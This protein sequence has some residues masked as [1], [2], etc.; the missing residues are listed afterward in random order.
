[1]QTEISQ[2]RATLFLAKNQ[3]LCPHDSMPSNEIV[4]D[5]ILTAIAS[6]KKLERDYNLA[7]FV[8][9]KEEVQNAD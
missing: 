2:I 4:C 5:E 1:M 3:I 6:L 8:G 9:A 7:D